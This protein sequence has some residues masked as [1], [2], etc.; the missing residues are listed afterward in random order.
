M[1]NAFRT[2][3]TMNEVYVSH[4]WDVKEFADRLGVFLV[5]AGVRVQPDNQMSASLGTALIVVM[6]PGAE[7]SDQVDANIATAAAAGVPVVP[8]LRHDCPLLV[9]AGLPFEEVLDDNDYHHDFLPR[10]D[11]VGRIADAPLVPVGGWLA[12]DVRAEIRRL[13]AEAREHSLLWTEVVDYATAAAG[14]DHPTT[15]ACRASALRVTETLAEPSLHC[16]NDAALLAAWLQLIADQA[17]VLGPDHDSTMLS[18]HW[19]AEADV[20]FNLDREGTIA[21]LYSLRDD[22]SR[23][24]GDSHWRWRWTENW[25][26][27]LDR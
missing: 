14:A 9:L 8:V 21:R 25:L 22:E 27:S 1:W 20:W 2:L 6:S 23:I 26:E 7:A 10:D 16:A 5:A 3:K 11:F 13:A 4:G 17:R 18:R 24:Y 12:A 15:L 19:L